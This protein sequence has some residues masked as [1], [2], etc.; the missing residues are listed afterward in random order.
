MF[1]RNGGVMPN[2]L[3]I[4]AGSYQRQFSFDLNEERVI[5]LPVIDGSG[6]LAIRAMTTE[7]FRPSDTKTSSDDRLLG[8]WC[9]VR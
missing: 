9:E 7:G 4:D 2:L 6:V 1:V 8:L 3:T 5:E